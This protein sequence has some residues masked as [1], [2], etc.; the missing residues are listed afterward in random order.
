MTLVK[1]NNDKKVNG[2][3]T[4][5]ELFDSFLKD[6]YVGDK[7]ISKV[8]AV[9]VSE[10]ESHY[11]LELAAPGM[12]KDDFKISLDKDVLKIAADVKS[13]EAIE[14][15]KLNRQEFNYGSFVRSFNLPDLIDHSKIEATYVDGILNISIA[16]K[17]EAKFLTRD[18]VIS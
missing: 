13:K 15:K 7:V 4:F 3:S 9:N 14:G 12:K 5:N 1:F 16:K 11:Y 17:E 6:S 2:Y 8:P 10:T 18:I